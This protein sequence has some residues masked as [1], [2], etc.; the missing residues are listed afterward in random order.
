MRE[1][2]GQPFEIG[3]D[4]VAALIPEPGKGTCK[5]RVV[6]HDFLPRRR[7]AFFGTLPRSFL[8]GFQCLCRGDNGRVA[9]RG[10]SLDRAGD[11]KWTLRALSR[12]PARRDV[13]LQGVPG[14]CGHP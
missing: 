14:G 13:L 3:E 9:E 1:A 10:M 6:I 5:I 11:G 7:G 4:P 8:E 12:P 2:P